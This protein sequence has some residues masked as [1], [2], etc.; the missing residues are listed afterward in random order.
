MEAR[1]LFQYFSSQIVFIELNKNFEQMFCYTNGYKND[2]NI[3]EM[4][5]S[6]NCKI[7]FLVMRFR[8]EILD[9][10]RSFAALPMGRTALKSWSD[11]KFGIYLKDILILDQIWE[12]LLSFASPLEIRPYLRWLWDQ[13]IWIIEWLKK[14]FVFKNNLNQKFEWNSYSIVFCEIISKSN[15][16]NQN[17]E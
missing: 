16:K 9:L 17:F 13:I 15:K 2:F 1:V 14:V 8:M 12:R 4:N 6:M 10:N 7:S 3:I 5:D 11:L